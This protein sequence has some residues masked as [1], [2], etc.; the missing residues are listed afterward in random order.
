MGD[1]RALC[2]RPG[3]AMGW[4]ESGLGSVGKGQS[5]LGV[6][7][8]RRLQGMSGLGAP[9][10]GVNVRVVGINPEVIGMTPAVKVEL[11]EERALVVSYSSWS[12]A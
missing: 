4:G 9:A 12:P 5:A 2:V 8:E 6:H 10:S 1:P 11:G 3:H 7:T